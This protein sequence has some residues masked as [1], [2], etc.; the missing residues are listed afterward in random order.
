MNIVKSKNKELLPGNIII[1]EDSIEIKSQISPGKS[2]KS[3]DTSE[4]RKKYFKDCLNLI[5]NEVV[6]GSK[7]IFPIEFKE[8]LDDFSIQNPYFFISFN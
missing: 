4:H 2:F 8:Q 5:E 6:I 7:L 3:N 1:H